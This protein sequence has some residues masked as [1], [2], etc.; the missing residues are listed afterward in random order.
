MSRMDPQNFSQLSLE[1]VEKLNLERSLRSDGDG[2]GKFYVLKIN[3]R[4]QSFS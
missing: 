1:E 4:H 3:T 2:D